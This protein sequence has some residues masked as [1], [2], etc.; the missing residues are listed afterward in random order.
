LLA[1]V[2]LN[3]AP[4]E[5]DRKAKLVIGTV[6]AVDGLA[7]DALRAEH[8]GTH[9][10]R[11]GRDGIDLIARTDARTPGRVREVEAGRVPHSW[12]HS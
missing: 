2:S 8:Q 7:L 1:K 6:P 12:L 5:F 3:A 9:Y 10:V 4:I 11:R